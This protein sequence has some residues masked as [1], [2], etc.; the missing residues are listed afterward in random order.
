[1]DGVSLVGLSHKEKIIRLHRAQLAATGIATEAIVASQQAGSSLVVSEVRASSAKLGDTVQRSC[2]EIEGAIRE[3]TGDIAW[4][5]DSLQDALV[6]HLGAIRWELSQIGSTLSQVL[7]TL[8][9]SRTVEAQQLLRQARRHLSAGEFGEAEERLQEAL[10]YDSTDFEVL[11]ELGYTYIYLEDSENAVRFFNK[12]HM[13][14]ESLPDS[15]RASTLLE[16]A[17]VYYA[18]GSAEDARSTARMIDGLADYAPTG[19]DLYQVARYEALVNRIPTAIEYLSRAIQLDSRLFATAAVDGEFEDATD[20]VIAFLS[21]L[22]LR[23]KRDSDRLL[24]KLV[25]SVDL[26]K[27]ESNEEPWKSVCAR[28]VSLQEEWQSSLDRNPSYSTVLLAG[29][30]LR[31]ASVFAEWAVELRG[32]W[33]NRK[34][35][36]GDVGCPTARRICENTAGLIRSLLAVDRIEV[37]QSWPDLREVLDSLNSAWSHALTVETDHR[38]YLS[39]REPVNARL[40]AAEKCSDERRRIVDRLT[41]S[42]STDFGNGVALLIFVYVV[43]GLAALGA[44]LRNSW[45]DSGIIWT[46][47]L[48]PIGLLAGVLWPL[49]LAIPSLRGDLPTGVMWWLGGCA[50]VSLIVVVVIF[51]SSVRRD[52]A[53]SRAKRAADLAL[54]ARQGIA[55]ELNVRSMAH[56][57]VERTHLGKSDR[58]LESV[59]ASLG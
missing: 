36:E 7:E 22:A 32:A 40:A 16:L 54:E 45:M 12:A 42:A 5:I 48:S 30:T 15:L 58:L 55:N 39:W 44:F 31:P 29:K 57:E 34:L 53:V 33:K 21:D 18:S 26:L 25:G 1:M 10:H 13:L 4:A 46:V 28:L 2:Q 17:R 41:K 24:R 47:I 27:R 52:R 43:A 51:V 38:E 19:R 9:N 20:D 14:P 6:G 49:F 37:E 11:T 23:T 59:R 3:G 8:R 50:A 56:A 35:P